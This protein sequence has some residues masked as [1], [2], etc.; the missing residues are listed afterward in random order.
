MVN[1]GGLLTSVCW[2]DFSDGLSPFAGFFL[3]CH[4][5][6]V[7][8][9]CFWCACGL[10]ALWR[11]GGLWVFGRCVWDGLLRCCFGLAGSCH[12][13]GL[14]LFGL[15]GGGF[16]SCVLSR[17]VDTRAPRFPRF[18]VLAN[19]IGTLLVVSI[20]SRFCSPEG[21]INSSCGNYGFFLTWV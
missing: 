21:V 7:W 2:D 16:V 5:V 20:C 6:G 14:V 11:V 12:C 17:E 8:W 1:F 9:P 18:M 15:W 13:V 4:R 10:G 19:F 3:A